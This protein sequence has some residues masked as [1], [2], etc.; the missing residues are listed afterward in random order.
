[1]IN[2]GL[3]WFSALIGS[4]LST[5]LAVYFLITLSDL[6]CDY[7]NARTCCSKLNS[8]IYHEAVLTTMGSVFM[9]V[10]HSWMKLLLNIPLALYTLNKLMS[11][12]PGSIGLYDPTEIHN[13]GNLKF[14][15]KEVTF[16]VVYH[17]VMFLTNMYSLIYYMVAW[18]H[19]KK[20]DVKK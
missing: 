6:E 9:I 7:L 11:K 16:K 12:R 20:K 18:S 14:H 13:R 10:N 4:L 17:I 3:I 1:M 5:I 19:W 2:E 15:M 8:L